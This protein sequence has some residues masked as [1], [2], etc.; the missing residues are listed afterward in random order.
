MPEAV[1]DLMRAPFQEGDFPWPV[2]Y[3]YLSVGVVERGPGELQGRRVFALAPHQERYIVPADALT[4][5]PDDV[6]SDRAV[7]A[8]TVETAVNAIWDAAP[9]YGDRVAVVGMGMVGACVT[10]LLAEFPLE[11]LQLVEVDP[12]TR[13]LC[14]I[15]G[16]EWTTAEDA[17]DDC[18]I[19]VHC[20]A[21]DAGLQTALRL[22][23]DDADIIE[24]SWFGD[25]QP[26][27]PLGADFHARRLRIRASQVGGIAV[28][29]RHR[30]T[31][32]DRLGLALDAL[33][34]PRFDLLLG[35]GCAFDDL[36][37]FLTGLTAGAPARGL[38]QLV[39]Y[40]Y[41]DPTDP[42]EG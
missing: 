39:R 36:P 28:A 16:A 7:L 13:D 22:A 4:P 33:R 20:S 17:L 29:R 2:K 21:T 11:R 14:E 12:K 19:V 3:G 35:E 5:I 42:T 9:H 38:C 31:H 24:L 37:R 26:R 41:P 10:A 27:L 15:F 25:H 23:G 8:G 32:A 30:R 18:D 6:P 40:P 1:H 34:D